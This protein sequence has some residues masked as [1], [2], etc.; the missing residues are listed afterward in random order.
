MILNQENTIILIIDIQEKLINATFNKD[1]LAQKAKI[2]VKAA[3]ILGLPIFVTEQYP[4]GLGETIS[5]I[6]ENAKVFIKTD[7]NALTDKNLLIELKNTNKKQIV[8]MGIE[9]HIC[10]HQT[11]S[12]LIKEGFDVTIAKDACGSRFENE[13][14]SALDCMKQ[15]GAKIKTTEMIL[16][17][18]LK[19]AKHPHFKEIQTLI[20]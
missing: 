18:F 12:A 2:L 9:T 13:Y 4:Q 6:K 19:S 10:V 7:F 16:F 5:S 3:N 8:I 11:V 14:T 17:E 15:N 1:L 20:K